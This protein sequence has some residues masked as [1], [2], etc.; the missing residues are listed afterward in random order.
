AR[1]QDEEDPLLDS[2]MPLYDV[3]E[4]HRI[5]V[6]APADVT[7]AVARDMNVLDSRVVRA[8]FK[9]RELLLGAAPPP[10]GVA[11]PAGLV[12]SA[13][14][15]GWGVLREQAGRQIVLGAVTKPWEPNPVFRDLPQGEFAT[16]A[17]PDFVKIAW[18]LRA[19][20][21]ADG[22]CTFRTETRA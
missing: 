13:L 4:R 20:A 14:T 19:D 5:R 2:F 21:L 3:V 7:L 15:L 10:R 6:A 8:I 12:A 11:L 1:M 17:A 22:A 16:F 9:G 18:T